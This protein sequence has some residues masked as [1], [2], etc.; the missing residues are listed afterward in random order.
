MIIPTILLDY[1]LI[2]IKLM[3]IIAILLIV[4]R[5]FHEMTHYYFIRKYG[6]KADG[7]HFNF[8]SLNKGGFVSVDSNQIIKLD[9]T[10]Q[11]VI[12]LSGLFADVCLY[13]IIG[14]I[15]YSLFIPS[16]FWYL[17]IFATIII[18]VVDVKTNLFNKDSDF[19]QFL[20]LI[21]IQ[22]LNKQKARIGFAR[23]KG[24]SYKAICS[25]KR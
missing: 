12:L 3:L 25:E 2:W 14:I 9:K 19:R 4:K 18:F 13:I 5:F 6:L 24:C 8:F 16:A 15:Y 7:I 11:S 21:C 10:K 20:S 17:L 23:S 1:F 22:K